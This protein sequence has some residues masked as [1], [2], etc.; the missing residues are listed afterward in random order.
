MKVLCCLLEC[1]ANFQ[2]SETSGDQ[3]SV[4]PL[5]GSRTLVQGLANQLGLNSTVPYRVWFGGQQ[6][7]PRIN[8][9]ISISHQRP[10]HLHKN[11]IW[12]TETRNKFSTHQTKDETNSLRKRRACVFQPRHEPQALQQRSRPKTTALVRGHFF[13]FHFVLY[14]VGGWTQVYGNIL[15]F[16]T[17]RGASHEAPFSQP[18]RSLVLF[19]SFLQGM[20]LPEMF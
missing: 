13:H 8:F 16:A 12:I 9:P 20:P 4:I 2:V 3:D 5:T 1:Y 14:Q 15:S 18:E 11:F 7:I 17:I 10:T 19:K 6:V